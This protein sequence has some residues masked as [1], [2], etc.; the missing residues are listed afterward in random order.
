MENKHSYI[1]NK[2]KLNIFRIRKKQC[3][4]KP[5]T[6]LLTRILEN[7]KRNSENP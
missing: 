3:P 2:L 7:G 6:L 5:L 1:H 4:T